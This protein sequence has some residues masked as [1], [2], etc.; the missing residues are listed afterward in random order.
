MAISSGKT[1]VDDD[2]VVG[3]TGA[4]ATVCNVSVREKGIDREP[5]EMAVATGPV[6][7][8]VTTR[9]V[10]VTPLTGG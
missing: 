10:V 4:T 6:I 8:P 9:F 3:V 2:V 5:G 7:V 1:V